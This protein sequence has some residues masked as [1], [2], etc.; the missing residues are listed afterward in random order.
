MD[1]RAIR[2]EIDKRI[3][4]RDHLIEEVS[5]AKSQI[6]KLKRDRR[7]V[8]KAQD[9][10]QE[11]ARQTQEKLKYHIEEIITLSLESVFAESYK[12]FVGFQIKRGQTECDLLLEEDGQTYDPLSSTGGGVVDIIAS[13]LR[14]SMW[15]LKQRKSR[16]VFLLDE[17]FR[18]LSADLQGKAYKMIEEIAEKLAIQF[19]IVTHSEK[20]IHQSTG[21]VYK[22][23]KRKQ[24]GDEFSVS[25]VERLQ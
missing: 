25:K 7:S 20:W 11:V 1:L 9:I 21:T 4:K 16:P 5:A 2:R 6:R 18:M 17:P 19:I 24:T 12:F 3:G 10:L 14:I 23:T 22:I 8:E 15:N 13:T